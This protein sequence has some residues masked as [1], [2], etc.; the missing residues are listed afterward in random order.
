MIDLN[1]IIVISLAILAFFSFCIFIVI[2]PIAFQ[3]SRTL[4]SAKFLF[5]T[6]NE[7]EPEIKEVKQNIKN[8]K[9]VLQQSTLA[10]KSNMGETGIFLMS[11]VYGIMAGV[12]EYFS[13]CKSSEN[14]Y[15]NIESIKQRR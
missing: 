3:L 13:D 4:S 7:F 15:N 12:K 2:I 14:G 11:S 8:V 10:A 9:N 5:D 6:V 1:L